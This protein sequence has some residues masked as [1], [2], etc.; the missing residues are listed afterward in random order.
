MA[1]YNIIDGSRP[2]PSAILQFCSL[3]VDFWHCFCWFLHPNPGKSRPFATTNLHLLMTLGP[4][5]YWFW[6]SFLQ[7]TWSQSLPF[8]VVYYWFAIDLQS[9][10]MVPG[11]SFYLFLAICGIY[12]FKNNPDFIGVLTYY[13][14]FFYLQLHPVH[15]MAKYPAPF[16]KCWFTLVFPF[17]W[18]LH[19]SR[20]VDLLICSC[21]CWFDGSHPF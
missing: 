14:W 21:F 16:Y 8:L 7:I 10:L 12:I 5:F 4:S 18:H 6:H 1:V 19:L 15:F 13:C 17:K 9:S 2:L 11:P 3:F 20:F